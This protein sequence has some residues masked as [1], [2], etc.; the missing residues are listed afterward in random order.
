M[1][2]ELHKTLWKQLCL[3]SLW[4]AGMLRCLRFGYLQSRFYCWYGGSAN[5]SREIMRIIWRLEQQRC[6]EIR[7]K[8]TTLKCIQPQI[9]A[10]PLTGRT[11]LYPLSWPKQVQGW[12]WKE[13]VLNLERP[14]WPAFSLHIILDIAGDTT[15]GRDQQNATLKYA[16]Y[17]AVVWSRDMY[18][19]LKSD[20]TFQKTYC[21][22]L[23]CILFHFHS[24]QL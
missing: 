10:S 16:E 14:A 18:Q 4:R 20:T 3:I 2:T 23:W 8:R 17:L 1:G 11:F 12:F 19:T 24:R 22:L 21:T 9:S 5:S 15:G 7:E 13:S 6:L